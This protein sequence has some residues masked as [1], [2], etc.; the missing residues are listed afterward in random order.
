M[1]HML[2]IIFQKYSHK[3]MLQ[4]DFFHIQFYK[5]I[6]FE[7][8]K[9]VYLFYSQSQDNFYSINRSLKFF[10]GYKIITLYSFVLIGK[11][12]FKYL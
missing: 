2:I 4:V 10:S 8:E 3:I 12:K 5:S 6:R 1:R 7:S 9:E 11:F